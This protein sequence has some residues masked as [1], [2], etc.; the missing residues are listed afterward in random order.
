MKKM[1]WML[2]LFSCS[3]YACINRFEPID[4]KRLTGD[5]QVSERRFMEQINH[6]VELIVSGEH[7]KAVDSLVLIEKEF[8]GRYETATN[9]GTAYELNG[10]IELA[11]VWIK[12]GLKLNSDAHDGTEWLHDK[13]LSAKKSIM[14]NPDWLREHSILNTVDF[15]SAD[16]IKAI[17]YQLSERTQFVKPPDPIVADLYYLLGLV[18]QE[19]GNVF[20]MSTSFKDS[21]KFN[22][23]RKDA[24]L[25]AKRKNRIQIEP[26][27]IQK[28]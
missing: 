24:I 13:I 4:M 11:S 3:P 14:T 16:V 17:E 19:N 25:Q 7:R 10:E 21:L 28:N 5:N 12:R 2:L 26:L 27:I 20:K 23:L 15:D 9:L 22:A 6:A 18:H 1:S 8:P